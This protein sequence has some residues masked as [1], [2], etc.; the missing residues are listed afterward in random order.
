MT[1]DLDEQLQ[2]IER[3]EL[4]PEDREIYERAEKLYGEGQIDE[5]IPLFEQFISVTPHSAYTLEST[6]RW[7]LANCYAKKE[8]PARALQQLNFAIDCYD[9]TH[10]NAFLDLLEEESN[11]LLQ[12]HPDLQPKNL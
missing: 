6:A 1:M 4:S 10:R 2:K 11:T 5:A 3:E 9:G 12:A 8:Q 7:T